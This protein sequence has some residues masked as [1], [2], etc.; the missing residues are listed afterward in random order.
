MKNFS[1][2]LLACAVI[3]SFI[4]CEDE[5]KD[6][7][8]LN[9]ITTGAILRTLENLS[10]T[11]DRS[12]PASSSMGAIVEFDDF[13]NDDL[14]ESVDVY[15]EFID[16]TPDENFEVQTVPEAFVV[17]IPGTAFDATATGNPT[18][19]IIVNMGDALTALGITNEDLYGGDVFILRFVLKLT[20]GRE[21]TSTNVGSAIASSSAFRSP[22]RYSAAVV[23]P[24]LAG[25]WII[26]MQDSYGDGWNG[27]KMAVTVGD[28]TTEYTIESGASAQYII[29]VPVGTAALVFNYS[30]GD[31]ESE[32]TWQITSPQNEV[33]ADEGPDPPTGP[34]KLT[35]DFCTL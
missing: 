1:S 28:T 24:P 3:F 14:L 11:V 16:T 23:C 8:D 22:F 33:V 21:F 17:N 31:W 12:D 6:R 32:V 18:A 19:T 10:A 34:V 2:I 7:L 13:L 30:A 35:L 26:D 27:A 20:D 9:Q 4:S 5:D 15:I 29:D 25:Q